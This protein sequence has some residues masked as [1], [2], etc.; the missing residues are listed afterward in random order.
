ME[1]ELFKQLYGLVP[2]LANG[3]TLK[4]ANYSDA[5]IVLIYLWAVLHDRP[6]YWACQKKNWPLPYRKKPFPDNSTL[7]RR[8]RTPGVQALLQRI[9]QWFIETQPASDC[10]WID[11]KPLVIGRSSKDKQ[12]GFGYADRGTAKGYKLHAIADS[13]QGFTCWTIRPMNHAE[14]RVA[15]DLIPGLSGQGYLIGDGAYD[16]N[17]LYDLAGRQSIQLLAPQRIHQAKGIGHRAHSP[18]RLRSLALQRQ[19]QGR[20]LINSRTQIER[21]FGQLTNLGCG[22][23]P[24]PNWVRTQFRV[25]LW[26]RGKMIIHHLWR[27]KNRETVA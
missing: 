10:R 7:S 5:D 6:T 24:L 11:A 1:G 23:S 18:Y 21:M 13:S 19:R 20:N 16:K 25:E 2:R 14:A 3:Q 12:A 22:L 4:R 9:E 26:V 15:D 8:L 17:Y 27:W